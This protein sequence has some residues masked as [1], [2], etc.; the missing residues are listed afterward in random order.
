MQWTVD[1]LMATVLSHELS[2]DDVVMNGAASFIPVTAIGLAQR[3]HAAGL[4]HLGAAV[5]V[6]A[7]WPQ[8]YGSTVGTAYWGGATALLNHPDEFW[9]YLESGRITA[10]F[11]RGA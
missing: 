6:D 4:T 9:P 5:G 1:E 2:S 8:V 11:H 3:Q 10:T 7:H